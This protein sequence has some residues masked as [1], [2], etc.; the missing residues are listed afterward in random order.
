MF[1]FD[2]TGLSAQ[3]IITIILG[4][5]IIG[6]IVLI[7]LVIFYLDKI[8]H[9]AS[10]V[11]ALF[12]WMG[13]GV[14]KQQI[15]RQIRGDILKISKNLSKEL[16][17]AIVYDL[18][19]KWVKESNRETFIENN[20]V[21]IRMDNKKSKTKN[22][23]YAVHQYVEKG[24]LGKIKT[25]FDSKLMGALDIAVVRKF[26]S[27]LDPQ[28]LAFYH[29]KYLDVFLQDDEAKEIFM[30]IIE[31]DKSGLLAAILLKELI[32]KGNMI[33]PDMPDECLK[34]ES[35]QFLKFL[36]DISCKAPG[37]D[38]DLQFVQTYF[39]VAVVIIAKSDKLYQVGAKPY[40]K[41]AEKRINDGT[42]TVYLLADSKEK[43]RC[44]TKIASDLKVKYPLIKSLKEYEY[45][46]K[47]TNGKIIKGVCI[48]INTYEEDMSENCN[49]TA[50]PA[51]E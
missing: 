21:V 3:Q 2:V 47:L 4:S 5:G 51:S 42:T 15:S 9:F 16:N 48:A 12:S 38:V 23:V 11:L 41:M 36:Y 37:E 45:K 26:L 32:E 34:I 7:V 14:Q 30:G 20:K 25:Y 28:Y 39:Q 46:R 33:Y 49:E 19:V 8:E 29:E 35:R 40:Y 27:E 31:L 17:S 13:S 50:I 44:A 22:T 18:K 6:I 43:V 24:L 10:R 1:S